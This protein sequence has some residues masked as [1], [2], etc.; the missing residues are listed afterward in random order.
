MS[1]TLVDSRGPSIS[2]LIGA[3]LILFGYAIVRNAYVTI[4][5]SVPLIATAILCVGGGSTFILSAVVKCAAVNFPEI[6]GFATSIPMAAFG[7]S[8]FVL[9]WASAVLY[10]G[11]THGLLLMLMYLP[12]LIFFISYFYV[13]FLPQTGNSLQGHMGSGQSR[14]SSLEMVE[15]G[16]TR[17]PSFEAVL[18]NSKSLADVHGIQLFT[19]SLFWSHFLIMGLLAGIGQ[20][21]I[22]SC[23][24]IV[25]ALLTSEH[26][27]ST[28]SSGTD[29]TEE[30]KAFLALIQGTQSFH[31]GIIS[32]S[33]FTGRL[34]SGSFSD[35]LVNRLHMQRDWL[36]LGAGLFAF[37]GQVCGLFVT[38]SIHLW[39]ISVCS[40]LMYG[41]CFGSYPMIIGDAFGMKHFSQNWG[42]LA[43]SPIPTA[44]AFN[45]LFGKVYDENSVMD[46]MGNRE[47][48]L[49]HECYNYAF[50]VTLASSVAVLILAFHV[51]VKHRQRRVQ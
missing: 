43:L 7:L 17:Q 45:V 51:I 18:H 50:Q 47:C 14:R 12:A 24:Y 30:T 44:Y 1:G 38:S 2:M 36:L 16:H 34:C 28:L 37:I 39:A 22:Y 8:A 27:M 3:L 31:V 32:L 19:N 48:S 13:K 9:A 4:I 29:A 33:S 46:E 15:L 20:M 6:R 49:G 11:D 42:V 10:P 23:G 35:Y 40:G 21:Y 5:S 25:K 26:S 41:M